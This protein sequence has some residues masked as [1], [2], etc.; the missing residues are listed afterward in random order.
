MTRL[1]RRGQTEFEDLFWEHTTSAF[2]H[3]ER[4]VKERAFLGKA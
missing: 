3:Y 1:L 4:M 2:L